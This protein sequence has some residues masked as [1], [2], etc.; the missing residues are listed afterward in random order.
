VTSPASVAAETAAAAA[1]GGAVSG[2]ESNDELIDNL[3]D[4]NYIKNRHLERIFRSVDRADYY[5]KAVSQA[6]AKCSSLKP[7]RD[8]AANYSQGRFC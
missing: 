5:L 1:M 7:E 8:I 2:G 6:L 3:A 4:A